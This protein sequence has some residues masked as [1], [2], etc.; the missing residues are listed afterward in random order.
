MSTPAISPK[1]ARRFHVRL[2][3]GVLHRWLGQLGP[4]IVTGASDDDPSGIATY[5]AAGA[6]TGYRFLWTALLTL[7][8]MAAI[9]DMC[10][11]IGLVTGHGL[12]GTLRRRFPRLVVL[13]A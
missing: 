13:A 9:Q 12:A 7:P 4:G 10:A 5:S 11:R 8:M 2:R 3:Q 6:Q 1:P